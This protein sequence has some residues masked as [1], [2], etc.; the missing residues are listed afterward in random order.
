MVKPLMSWVEN[1][2]RWQKWYCGKNYAVSCRR[3]GVSPTKMG[4][5]KAANEWWRQKQAELDEEKQKTQAEA[6]RAK[7]LITEIL[8]IEPPHPGQPFSVPGPTHDEIEAVHKPLWALQKEIEETGRVSKFPLDA[9]PEPYRTRLLER[10]EQRKLATDQAEREIYQRL[11]RRF[12]GPERGGLGIHVTAFLK[13]KKGAVSVGRYSALQLALDSFKRFSGESAALKAINGETLLE[14]RK[15]L[16]ERVRSKEISPYTGRDFMEIV[17]QFLNWAYDTDRLEQLPKVMRGKQL[18]ISAPTKKIRVFP[19]G[20]FTTLLGHAP[21]RLK[22]CLL[23][24]ANCA[25]QQ[26]DIADLQ[27]EEVDWTEGYIERKRSKLEDSESEEIPTVRWKLWETT[28]ELLKKL[29]SRQGLVLLNKDGT[30]LKRQWFKDG[31]PAKSDCI[32]NDYNRLCDKLA[33]TVEGFQKHPLKQIRKTSSTLLAGHEV[34]GRYTTYF[35]G[36]S[37]RSITERHY[38]IPSQVLFDKAIAWLGGQYGIL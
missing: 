18:N 21:E 20:Y 31:K 14:Y 19:E 7:E 5:V 34:Y 16:V 23:L 10:L 36:N 9:I 1:E 22:L 37:P 29:G 17:K 8:T 32:K 25:F 28:F 35:L 24:M 4:S 33:Q 26:Q 30:P 13:Y 38:A 2:K 3:L 12:A 27:A 11:Q 15:H 6:L